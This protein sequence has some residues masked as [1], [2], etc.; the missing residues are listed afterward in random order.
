MVGKKNADR[1]YWSANRLKTA[2][3]EDDPL[4]EIII[5]AYVNRDMT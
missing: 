3:L 1:L 2:E 5:F 4:K